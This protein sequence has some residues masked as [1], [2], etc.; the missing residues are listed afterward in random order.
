MGTGILANPTSEND[1]AL[2]IKSD[3]ERFYGS[4][5]DLVFCSA[6]GKTLEEQ[7][8]WI[9]GATW[10][11]EYNLVILGDVSTNRFAFEIIRRLLSPSLAPDVSSRPVDK[12]DTGN[13]KKFTDKDAHEKLKALA[14]RHLGGALFLPARRITRPRRWSYA[15]TTHLIRAVS[16]GRDWFLA[17]TIR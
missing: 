1:L 12:A 7:V 14:K 5:V 13:R 6:L 9:E 10:L 17:S 8:E 11:P 4:E 15:A 2:V 3:L 16:G